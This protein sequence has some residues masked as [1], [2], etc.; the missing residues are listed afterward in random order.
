VNLAFQ[1]Q[2]TYVKIGQQGMRKWQEAE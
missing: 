2:K 1:E